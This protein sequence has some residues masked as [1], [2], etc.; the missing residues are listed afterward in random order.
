MLNKIPDEKLNDTPEEIIELTQESE[1]L[2]LGLK[3]EE[4]LIFSYTRVRNS[5]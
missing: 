5:Y 2:I 4:L 3:S 1:K